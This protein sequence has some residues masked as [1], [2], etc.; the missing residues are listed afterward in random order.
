MRGETSLAANCC[1][2]LWEVYDL[3]RLDFADAYLVASDERS[4]VGQIVLGESAPAGQGESAQPAQGTR[5]A[6]DQLVRD[7]SPSLLAL[8][9]GV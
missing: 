9:P 7:R 4:G 5:G 1:S 2:E 3:H 6:V 8:K